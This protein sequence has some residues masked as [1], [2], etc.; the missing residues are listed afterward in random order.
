MGFFT[1]TQ[2][3]FLGH[4][5]Y[6]NPEVYTKKSRSG[7]KVCVWPLQC[8]F[9]MQKTSDVW[10]NSVL[11]IDFICTLRL[12]LALSHFFYCNL[13]K[14]QN[15]LCFLS[16]ICLT[17]GSWFLCGLIIMQFA[18][19]CSN[20]HYWCDIWTLIIIHAAPLFTHRGEEQVNKNNFQ[21]KNHLQRK[22]LARWMCTATP[23]NITPVEHMLSGLWSQDSNFRLRL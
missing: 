5:F 9:G 6:N 10:F 19:I 22:K 1:K 7:H 12:N 3:G 4:V 16:A 2:V 14:I 21:Y 8:C 15:K 23:N 13:C 18:L 11:W 20:H 17:T